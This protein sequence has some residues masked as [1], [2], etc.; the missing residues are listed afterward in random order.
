MK[1]KLN[2]KFKFF[3]VILVCS[4]SIISAQKFTIPVLPDTQEALTRQRGIFFSQ[5]EWLTAK[6]DSLKAPMVLH[7][8]DLVN[9]DNFDQWELASV[10]MRILDRANIPY[11]ISLGNHDTGAVGMFSGS[12]APGNVN[13]NLRN[14]QKFN[15]FFPV[16]RFPL[17]KGRFEKNKSDNAYYTFEAGNL[18][19]IVVAIEFCA[20]EEAAQWMDQVLKEHP[21]HNAIVLTHYHLTPRG[22]ICP[23]NAGY[24]DM[25]VI[26]IF[27]QY[28]KPNKNVMMVLSGHVCGS[29]WKIDQ[30]TEGN[31]IYQIL[32][33]FQCKD[34]G[35][36]RLLEIDTEK[37]TISAKLYSP[38]L[39]KIRDDEKSAFSF[40][41]VKF[42]R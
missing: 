10:G 38:Y 17:Q 37:G 11:A 23:N 41:D 32:Q 31:T 5:I 24:G 29:A 14:T 36:L 16:N 12:A 40:S 26:D 28:I 22:E 7:V 4:C 21:D 39:D 6:A 20:R 27:E 34:E 15:Y 2:Q 30:G 1:T 13:V 9:F 18:K 25:K 19:W 8:G 33:N 42:I 35:Y 3:C